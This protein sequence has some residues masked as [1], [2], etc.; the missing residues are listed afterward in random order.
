[1]VMDKPMVQTDTE[2]STEG[3]YCVQRWT[4]KQLAV[5]VRV[6]CSD[7]LTCR[8]HPEICRDVTDFSSVHYPNTSSSQLKENGQ[9]SD[10]LAE[11]TT[12][13]S[14]SVTLLTS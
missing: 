12:R 8:G 6:L 9:G 7:I 2:D 10:L 13:F 1:M 4:M 14:L 5:C 3:A 11:L